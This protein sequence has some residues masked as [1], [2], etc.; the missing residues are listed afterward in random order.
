MIN[1]GGVDQDRPDPFLGLPDQADFFADQTP[2]HLE[3]PGHGL[4]QI[5]FPGHDGLF[6]GKPQQFAGHLGGALGRIRNLKQVFVNRLTGTGLVERHLGVAKNDAEHVVEI[7][8]H[9]S[10]QPTDGLHLLG[11]KELRRELLPPRFGLDS[12]GDIT[13]QTDVPGHLSLIVIQ[14]KHIGLTGKNHAF[15]FSETDLINPGGVVAEGPEFC[16]KP[17]IP[18]LVFK[19]ERGVLAKHFL[20]GISEQVD[21]GTVAVGDPLVDVQDKQGVADGMKE[22]A[23]VGFAPAEYV[24]GS[25]AGI[26]LPLQLK[27]LLLKF[28]HQP[29]I[30]EFEHLLFLGI[31]G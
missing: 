5:D 20:Q 10:G 13:D 9:S 23:I 14:P 12:L 21:K 28:P 25:V 11:L 19:E 7:V 29:L 8:G 27:H 26:D 17:I 24:L 31:D 3:H 30:V 6:A 4:I 15:F 2:Q 18:G 1:L 22:A 16:S